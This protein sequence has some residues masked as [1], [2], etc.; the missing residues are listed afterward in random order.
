MIKQNLFVV[1]VVMLGQYGKKKV[2]TKRR[3]E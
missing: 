1:A 2:K 3:I